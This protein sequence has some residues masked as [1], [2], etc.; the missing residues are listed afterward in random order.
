MFYLI[1]KYWNKISTNGENQRHPVL[2][3]EF[4]NEK[5]K[6]RQIFLTFQSGDSNAT[7]SVFFPPTIWI[8]MEGGEGDEIKS[9]QGS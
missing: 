8:F 6:K 1:S 5:K 7:F 2:C 9:R 3:V 4:G